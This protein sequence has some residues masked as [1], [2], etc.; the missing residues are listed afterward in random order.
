VRAQSATTESV[1]PEVDNT[2]ARAGAPA[3]EMPNSV[4]AAIPSGA[5]DFAPAAGALE[6][7]LPAKKRRSRRRGLVLI[8]IAAAVI[9]VALWLWNRAAGHSGVTNAATSPTS[10]AGG[11]HDPS[12][13]QAS[14]AGSASTAQSTSATPATSPISA[15]GAHEGN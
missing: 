15:S 6:P 3:L 12:S 4:P 13:S 8:L 14:G 2:P 7:S 1:E 5:D 9:A 10:R 11:L